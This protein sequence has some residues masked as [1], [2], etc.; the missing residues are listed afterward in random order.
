MNPTR[1]GRRPAPRLVHGPKNNPAGAAPAPVCRVNWAR[2]YRIIPARYPPVALFERVANPADWEDLLDVES[3]TNDRIRD[4]IGDIAVV[5]PEDRVS[6]P[7]ASWVMGS[8][9]HL[10]YPSRF[11]TGTFGVYYAA[12]TRECAVAE[13][14]Y[15]WGRFMASTDEPP[16]NL[17]MRVLIGRIDAHLH[18]IRGD[19]SRF[20]HLYHPEDYAPSQAFGDSLRRSGSDGI[21]YTSVRLADGD[22]VAA[23]RP[24][25]VGCPRG[26]V[27][28]LYHWNG[29]SIDRLFDYQAQRW[30]TL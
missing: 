18:D 20:R 6:G 5:P 7:G 17:D 11:S 8:F 26:D 28:L 14:A 10:G 3:L 15:H 4:E 19:G 30:E 16:T 27:F 29:A 13:T 22:C 9:T 2:S 23:F 24:R 1:E 21:V 25:V 12:H